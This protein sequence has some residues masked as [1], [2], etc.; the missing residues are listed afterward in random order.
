MYVC[1]YIFICIFMSI[2]LFIY[3]SI[4]LSI[5][6]QSVS[7]G[8]YQQLRS[9]KILKDRSAQ[10]TTRVRHSISL[11]ATLLNQ[12]SAQ[13]EKVKEHCLRSIC[14][15]Q[16]YCS[17]RAH[18]SNSGQMK[19][20]KYQSDQTTIRAVGIAYFL[21]PPFPINRALNFAKLRSII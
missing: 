2:N 18:Q 5:Y 20:L 9:M 12:Q 6:D 13:L 16:L 3:L 15:Q 19:S 10:T 8:T 7:L 17:L 11:V 4:Y 14:E 21:W 1:T